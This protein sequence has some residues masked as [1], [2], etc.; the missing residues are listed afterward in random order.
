MSE[1]ML[2]EGYD[3]ITSIDISFSCVKNMIELYRDK[4]LVQNLVYK[5]M[6][7]RNL[8]FANG[9]FEAVVDKGTFDCI[10][11]GDG[12]DPNAEQMLSEIERVLAPNGVYICI[13]YGNPLSR[14]PMFS[15]ARYG[16][17]VS[18]EK[19][20]K[21]NLAQTDAELRRDTNQAIDTNFY[22]IYIT[23]K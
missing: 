6:D 22:Y 20:L 13:S 23:R 7:V 9:S 21:P 18:F 2:E 8:Q 16:W 19:I 5:Q 1:E 12:A 10:R 17:T 4:P 11:C 15:D 14:M 3:K